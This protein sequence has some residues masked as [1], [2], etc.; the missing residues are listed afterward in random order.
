MHSPRPWKHDSVLESGP[1]RAVHL[2][3][4]CNFILTSIL[5]TQ[6]CVDL[7]SDLQRKLIKIDLWT[8]L[9]PPVCSNFPC[10]SVLR[11]P[12][13]HVAIILAAITFGLTACLS[14]FAFIKF[15][16]CHSEDLTPCRMTGV[17]LQSRSL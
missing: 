6:F 14:Q 8:R 10:K 11:S 16:A 7:S 17:T 5:A 13:K 3:V 2:S 15:G 12:R 4:S 1:P 9:K